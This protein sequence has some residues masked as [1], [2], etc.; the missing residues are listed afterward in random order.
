MAHGLHI[1]VIGEKYK[2]IAYKKRNMFTFHVVCLEENITT[3]LKQAFD[4]LTET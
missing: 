2:R 3:L 4:P 1:T